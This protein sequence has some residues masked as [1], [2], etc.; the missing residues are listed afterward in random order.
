VKGLSALLGLVDVAVNNERDLIKCAAQQPY[1]SGD[2]DAYEFGC[3]RYL[4]TDGG[5]LF[6]IQRSFSWYE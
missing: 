2:C 3:T 5:M 6:F 4:S 1:V